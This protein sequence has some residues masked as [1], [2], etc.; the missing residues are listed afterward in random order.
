YACTAFLLAT[1]PFPTRR[2]PDLFLHLVVDRGHLQRTVAAGTGVLG[3]LDRVVVGAD[4]AQAEP[5]GRHAALEPGV[6][7]ARLGIHARVIRQRRQVP[8]VR[9]A[10]PA[11]LRKQP[12]VAL[13][14]VDA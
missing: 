5:G 14:A 3:H 8:V 11:A 4:Q 7:A 10:Q 9:V 1:T 12:V 13:L 2:S 6:A